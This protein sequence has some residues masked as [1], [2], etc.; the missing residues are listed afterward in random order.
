MKCAYV[1]QPGPPES[2]IYGDQP[3]PVVQ[4]H[5]VLVKVSV[6][7][8]NP[9]DTY[10]R[11]GSIPMPVEFPYTPGC[12]LAGTVIAIGENVS[13]FRVG[14]RVWG[15]NQGLFKR[16][17]TMAELAA[18]DEGWLYHTPEGMSD[19]D[20]AAG[21]LTGITS[22]LGL[23]RDAQLKAGEWVFVN[24]G[25]GGVGSM[26][27]QL[28]KAAGARVVTTAGSEAKRQLCLELGADVALDYKSTTLD[29]EIKAATAVNGGIDVWWETQREPNI[30]RTIGLMKRRGR[31]VVMAG[32]QAQLQFTL[33]PFY[34][35]DLQLLG[36]AM[37][38][39]SPDEQR[40][41]ADDLNEWYTQGRWKPLIG[42]R[43][44]L[45]EAAAAHRLQEEN[46]LGQKHTLTGKV[47]VTIG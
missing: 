5:Q 38:N 14:D 24:G 33:G 16:Q 15:T 36:F 47:L 2:L 20:A 27:L 12:D 42:A 19:E 43:F 45:I 18:V 7:A 10:I 35:N 6:S 1:T 30:T 46:T 32:R 13:R 4:A 8:I 23:F 28:A 37:F 40:R 31:I 3:D 39:A 29:D 41:S 34:T 25:T 17:G 11:A 22:H 9:I 21:A 26:V 44:P